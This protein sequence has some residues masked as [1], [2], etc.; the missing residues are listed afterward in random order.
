M[1]ALPLLLLVPNV[2]LGFTE[3]MYTPLDKATNI[4]VPL[5]AYMLLA[6]AWK[7]TG[8]TTILSLPVM[9][10][11]AFQIVLLYLYGES[12]IAIDMFLNVA[13]TNPTEVSELLGNLGAAITCVCCLYIPPLA[14][15]IYLTIK[16]KYVSAAMRKPA[17]AG[18]VIILFAG[19][20]CLGYAYAKDSAYSVSRKLFPVNVISNLCEA[21]HRAELS[22]NYFSA[23]ECF[24]FDAESMRTDSIAELYILVIGETERAGNWQLGGYERATNPQLS[25]R[26]G[27]V[28]FP[29]TLSESN[30]T[31]KSVPLLMSHL[32]AGE[33]ADSIYCT[34]GVI[35]AFKE[36]GYRTY[37]ISN[38][39]HNGSLIDFF[40][41]AADSVEFIR[42]ETSTHYDE[43]LCKHLATVLNA[44]SSP[45]IFV[46]L[47]S[48]GS[49]FNYR[50]RYPAQF[51]VFTPD[52]VAEASLENRS[53]LLNAYDNS[54]VYTDAVLDNIIGMAESCGRNAA[55]VYL[56]DH[57]EDIYDDSRKRFLHASPTPTYW[58]L[59]VPMFVWTSSSYNERHP[60][61]AAT[62]SSNSNLNVSSSRSTFHTLL[63]LAAIGTPRYRPQASLTS[64]NYTEPERLYLTDYNE[65]VPL[66]HSGMRRS[67]F[68][69]LHLHGIDNFNDSQE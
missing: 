12:I 26:N 47:H 18:G 4:L 2:A 63:G 11:C 57:G 33:F 25:L 59:H 3:H 30:T 48:Y 62:L 37:W 27:L 51:S 69:Q 43:E 21:F 54:I 24:T 19:I 44:D 38:Q 35:S 53:E 52:N 29:R 64:D 31:H 68:S 8:L 66:N 28:Y 10:L 50:E 39:E 34:K 9:I 65:A 36:A 40:G 1:W 32:D 16:K 5:G 67:D 23:S 55:V 15:G 61:I 13:T 42:N 46:A 6:A 49:H 58:Q 17:L 14:L 22:G 41:M 20:V 60:D 45:K 7:K 56:A